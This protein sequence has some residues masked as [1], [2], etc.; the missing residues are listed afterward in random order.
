MLP[1]HALTRRELL[2]LGA[3]LAA[4][5]GAAAVE[6][7]QRLPVVSKRVEKVFLAPG[8][9]PNG[10][11]AVPDG[12]WILDQENPNKAHQVRYEDGKVLVEL[13]TESSHG[14]GITYG[15]GALWIASTYGLTTLK[16]DPKTGWGGIYDGT[17]TCPTANDG[18]VWTVMYNGLLVN[19]ATGDV[20]SASWAPDEYAYIACL[21][22]R[23]GKTALWGYAPDNPSAGTYAIS[24][25]LRAPSRA[26]ATFAPRPMNIVNFEL[27]K[28]SAI[29]RHLGPCSSMPRTWPGSCSSAFTQTL[30][31][32]ALRS[33]MRANWSA[34]SSVA[35]TCAVNALVEHTLISG[36]ACT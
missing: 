2:A 35:S 23:I 13:Q 33:R 22:G 14:S 3:G 5:L 28:R 26:T 24:F 9:M 4:R 15:N 8:K 10:L 16:V 29:L 17:H 34:R 20:E 25:S 19:E 36:P 1:R 21:N 7:K 11:Q 30:P 12:L 32:V 31:S 6:D 18:N 27:P